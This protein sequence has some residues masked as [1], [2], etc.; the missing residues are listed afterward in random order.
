ML[1]K[2]D[3]DEENENPHQNA[4]KDTFNISFSG[5]GC[6]A[7]GCVIPAVIAMITAF[8]IS[9]NSKLFF[10]ICIYAIPAGLI[11]FLGGLFYKNSSK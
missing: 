1:Q 6:L 10:E 7:Y 4:S 9:G 11:G 5:T 3:P 8:L 2:Y